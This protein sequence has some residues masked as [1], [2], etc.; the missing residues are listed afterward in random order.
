MTRMRLTLCSGATGNALLATLETERMLTSLLSIRPSTLRTYL[1]GARHYVA[2]TK[3]LELPAFPIHS[4]KLCLWLLSFHNKNTMK[5]YNTGLRFFANLLA[6]VHSTSSPFNSD[7]INATKRAIKLRSPPT[8]KMKG[9]HFDALKKIMLQTETVVE[10][11]RKKER[12][13]KASRAYKFGVGCLVAYS[14]G[15]RVQDELLRLQRKDISFKNKSFT[16]TLATRKNKRYRSRITRPCVCEE[17]GSNV[18]AY[19]KLLELQGNMSV[20]HDSC[21]SPKTSRW[22]PFS[23]KF[24]NKHLRST[25]KAFGVKNTHAYG[26]H[27]FRRGST[28]DFTTGGGDATLLQVLAHQGTRST[29]FKEYVNCRKIENLEFAPILGRVA[30]KNV[31][32]KAR[33]S[34]TTG[35]HIS[36][37]QPR[38]GGVGSRY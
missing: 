14:C 35:K 20:G 19:H 37:G 6:P 18:C 36:N 30:A 21:V 7:A 22:F 24:F 1:Q 3:T 29:S 9:I 33:S 10:A 31:K 2:F 28:E 12:M 38:K 16:V 17:A 25:L 32:K 11:L 5:N 27:S 26:S 15:L 8:K 23:L 4:D 13:S 34:R